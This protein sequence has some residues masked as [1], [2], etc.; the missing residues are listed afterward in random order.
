MA[1]LANDLISLMARG[2]LFLNEAPKIRLWRWM[3]YSRATTS[4]RADRP[5]LL[6]L[7]GAI[8][9]VEI[10]NQ[11]RPLAFFLEETV[12]RDFSAAV[13]ESV[14]LVDSWLAVGV[15]AGGA[16][17]VWCVRSGRFWCVTG[18]RAQP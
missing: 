11:F 18:A 5:G 15:F 2:A 9:A 16:T 14:R 10:S 4:A 13:V 12:P 3:V 8:S 17:G 7:G 1:V 6:V